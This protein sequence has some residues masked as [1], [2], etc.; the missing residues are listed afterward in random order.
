MPEQSLLDCVFNVWSPQIG[1]PT[2]LGWATV[3]AYGFTALA[4]FRIGRRNVGAERWLWL[5]C[6]VLLALLMVN[7]QLDLQSFLTAVGRCHALMTDWYENRRAVQ[8]AFIIAVIV[9]TAGSFVVLAVLLRRAF[10]RN[11]LLFSGLLLL[12]T[13]IAVRAVGFHRFDQFIAN[14]IGPFRMNHVLEL[15]AIGIMLLACLVRAR[16]QHRNRDGAG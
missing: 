6:S 4:L 12:L 2:P 7:K 10:L 14:A 13:F 8:G 11:F 1:D 3:V 9:I 16:T 5:G 15:G